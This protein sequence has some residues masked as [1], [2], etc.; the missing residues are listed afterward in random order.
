MK[1][2]ADREYDRIINKLE[3]ITAVQGHSHKKRK[4]F[5]LPYKIIIFI[6]VFNFIFPPYFLPVRGKFTSGF[7]FRPVPEKRIIPSLE[8]HRGLDIA[9]PA[10][11]AVKASKSGF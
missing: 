9:S 1:R 3:K 7:F 6:M 5:R 11:T 4:I 10:G 8:Y 2:A